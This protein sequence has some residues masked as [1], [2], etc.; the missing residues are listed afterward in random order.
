M[1][2]SEGLLLSLFEVKEIKE[3][4]TAQRKGDDVACRDDK[5]GRRLEKET[6]GEQ[7]GEK[8]TMK[9]G[10][11]GRER[12][13]VYLEFKIDLVDITRENLRNLMRRKILK[14]LLSV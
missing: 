13:R 11:V 4:M 2:G 14:S 7:E 8:G 5:E 9:E 12:L 3:T 1:H 6:Q 10:T